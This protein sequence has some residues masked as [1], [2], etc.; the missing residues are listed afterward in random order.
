[1]WVSDK[2]RFVCTHTHAI[3]SYMIAL[4]RDIHS[5]TL[6]TYMYTRPT[7]C[8]CKS[9]CIIT[10]TS[11]AFAIPHG[12]FIFIITLFSAHSQEDMFDTYFLFCTCSAKNGWQSEKTLTFSPHQKETFIS[13]LL[14]VCV[15]SLCRVCLYEYGAGV[16][17]FAV[18]GRFLSVVSQKSS[19][20]RARLR[21]FELQR[22]YA[23]I[24]IAIY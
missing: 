10:T 16:E 8:F 4:Y 15:Q 7:P 5:Y 20:N 22:L 18:F 11:H 12:T 3:H 9:Q 6:Y 2:V 23:V 13:S 21:V 1:M 24:F 19:L 17:L 14:A